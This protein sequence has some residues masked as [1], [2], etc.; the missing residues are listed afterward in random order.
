VTTALLHPDDWRYRERCCREAN[1]HGGDGEVQRGHALADWL[2]DYMTDAEQADW[3]NE[4]AHSA[5]S[6]ALYITEFC[7]RQGLPVPALT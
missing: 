4:M 7:F 3:L 2:M 6:G 5:S 1:A